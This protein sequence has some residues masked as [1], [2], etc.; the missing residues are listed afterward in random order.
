MPKGGGL[1]V[2]ALGFSLLPLMAQDRANVVGSVTDSTGA[3][4]PR[5]EVT[6]SIPDNGFV[7]HFVTNNAGEYSADSLPI[8]NCVVSAEARGF[9]KLVRTG[10]VLSVGQTLRVDLQ[11]VVGQTTSEVTITGNI[12]HVETETAAISSV[13]TGSQI[14]DLELNGRNFVQ[15]ATLIP[16]AVPDNGLDTQDVG[17]LGNNNISFNGGRMTYTN[18]EIDGGGNTDDTSAGTFNTYPSLDTI[19]EFRISTSNYSA[20]MGKHAGAQIEVA[21]RSGTKDFHGELFDYLRNDA[22]DANDW[23]ANRQINPPGGNAPKTPLKRNEFGYNFGGP[24]YIPGHYN[25]GKSK[26]FF[27]WSESWRRNRAGT[28]ISAGV[29]SKRMR[30]GDFSEC[31]P[32]STNFNTIIASNCTLPVNPLTGTGFSGDIVPVA[33]D[34]GALLDAYIPLPNNGLDGYTSALSLP[35][36]WRQEQIRVD[37]NLSDKTSAFVRFTQDAWNSVAAPSLWTSSNYDTNQTRMQSPGKSAVFHLMRNFSPRVMNEFIASFN[38]LHLNFTPVAGASSPAGSIDKPSDWTPANLFAANASNPLLPSVSICGGTPFC[39]LNDS[40]YYPWFFWV[41]IFNLK[42]N[43]A[44]TAGKQTFKFGFL[45]ATWKSAIHGFNAEGFMTFTGSGPITTNNALADT[46]LGRIEQYQEGTT[47]V[48]GVPVGGYTIDHRRQ[49]DTEFYFQDDWKVLR[50]LTLNLGVRYYL[51]EPYHDI[52]NP[53]VDNQF[54]PSLYNPSL[55]ALPDASGNL[56]PDPATGR[57]YDYTRYGNGLVACGVGVIRGGCFIPSRKNSARA[58]VW[59]C[60]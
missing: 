47:T 6:V 32:T 50:R 37:Q 58:A 15:L 12:P 22:L 39:A 38:E 13:V 23:F 41:R 33:T 18:W 25:T 48:N 17:V 4:V 7:R 5:A 11:L 52:T 20:D 24:F 59:V 40:S 26:T 16:G 34:G 35:T 45:R 56:V 3:V 30:Q 14:R 2:I 9:Q 43:V 57:I 49:N 51:F 60:V 31:D 29:P 55:Q 27:F 19:A 53:T 46:F 21:T 28:V 8:G 10:I 36:N 42:D 54:E 1:L 44:F